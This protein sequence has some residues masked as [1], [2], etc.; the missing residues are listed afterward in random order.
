MIWIM[1]R[2]RNKD[3]IKLYVA[4]NVSYA[5]EEEEEEAEDNNNQNNIIV[6]EG[7]IMYVSDCDTKGKQK[8][9]FNR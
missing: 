6:S 9:S 1:I 7:R 5:G 8:K 4:D 3:R 2:I